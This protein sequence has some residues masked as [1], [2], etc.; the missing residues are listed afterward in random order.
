M[1]TEEKK[2]PVATP[3]DL[4]RVRDIL[5]GGVIRETEARF[6]TLQRDLTRL[7]KALDRANEQL[8]A[9]DSAHNK[10]LQETRQELQESTD[11]LRSETRDALN[12]LGDEKV[13]REQLGNLFVEIGN[14]IKGDGMLTSVL[15][16]LL[17]S[18]E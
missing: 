12:R 17:K 18:A 15:D 3:Q 1:S 9:Q 14:Q 2:S 8:A 13:D 4:D 7:Q 11:E 6:T 16:G 5:F 10:R